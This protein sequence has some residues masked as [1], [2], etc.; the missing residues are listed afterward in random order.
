MTEHQFPL[1]KSR[2]RVSAILAWADEHRRRTGNWPAV[3]SGRV[4]L[5]RAET[6]RAVSR[7]LHDGHRGLPGGSSLAKLLHKR[8][9]YRH[10]GTLVPIRKRQILAWADA[11]HARTGQWPKSRTTGRI[12]ESSG[13]TW[14][15]VH[16]SLRSGRRGLPGG[17]TLADML[18]K[19]RGVQ[20]NLSKSRLTM[21]QILRWADEHHARTGKWPNAECGPI[22][23]APGETWKNIAQDLQLGFRGFAGGSSLSRLL[24]SHRGVRNW[25]GLPLLTKP[26]IMKWAKMHHRRTGQWPNRTSGPVVDAPGEKWGALDAA[27][28]AGVRGL[29]KGDSLTRMIARARGTR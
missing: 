7:A 5:A 4:R 11:Y 2:L 16:S 27:F 6:W 12:P 23:N 17:N 18:L 14:G 8:R 1:R 25:R 24:R 29:H 19:H 22:I 15:V 13:D 26:K 21:R 28:Y 10:A 9:G 20:H 3:R